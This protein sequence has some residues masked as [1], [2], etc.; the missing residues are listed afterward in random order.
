MLEHA[1]I[2]VSAADD[3]RVIRVPLGAELAVHLPENASTGFRWEVA[4][5][6]RRL[7]EPHGGDVLAPPPSETGSAGTRTF[8]FRALAPG[9]GRLGFKLWRPWEGDASV[10]RRVT[11]TV[12]VERRQRDD[13]PDH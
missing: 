3:G 12:L 9:R 2:T 6:A 8:V 5:P 11:V 7:M 1:R 10:T 13:A 4:Q